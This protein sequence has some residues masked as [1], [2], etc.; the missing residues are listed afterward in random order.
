VDLAFDD[1][2][3]DNVEDAWRAVMGLTAGDQVSPED[4]IGTYMRFEDREHMAEE[5]DFDG[6]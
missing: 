1:R 3:L 6:A 5:E 4:L 2:T